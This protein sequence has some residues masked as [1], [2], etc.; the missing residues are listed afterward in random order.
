LGPVLETLAWLHH[1]TE[2]WLEVTVLLIPGQND[3]EPEV[4]RLCAWYYENLG[5]DVPLHFTAF[6][7]DFKLQNLPPT[8]AATLHRARAQ[9]ISTGLRYV[10]TGN[11]H[12]PAGQSTLCPGCGAR[13]IARDR[14]TI[15]DWQLNETG[16]CRHCSVKVA[17][18]FDSRPGDWGGG[19]RRVAISN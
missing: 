15:E 4:E 18:H 5:P 13:L 8:P 19:R 17:G 14:Y 7:P 3:S 9:A 6:H 1:E 11:I 2:V 16:G 12:D 10:Y